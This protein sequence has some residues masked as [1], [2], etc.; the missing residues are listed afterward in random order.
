MRV[1]IADR[2]LTVQVENGITLLSPSLAAVSTNQNWRLKSTPGLQL[3][4]ENKTAVYSRCIGSQI[5]CS[6]EFMEREK[7]S[8]ICTKKLR[9]CGDPW[10]LVQNQLLYFSR[11]KKGTRD[12]ASKIKCYIHGKNHKESLQNPGHWVSNKVLRFLA[13]NAQPTQWDANT[14]LNLWREKQRN[15][16]YSWH[17]R[18]Q[19]KCYISE[20]IKCLIPD[21]HGKDI[22]R[23][24]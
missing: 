19:V 12:N 17:I 3:R 13:K 18:S 20:K 1:D 4:P 2:K 9:N 16:V 7:K 15:C 8:D 24:T 5:K 6:V 10:Y 23:R 22:S 11:K 14:M 21:C